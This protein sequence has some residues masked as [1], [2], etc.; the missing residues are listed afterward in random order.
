MCGSNY[1]INQHNKQYTIPNDSFL[2]LIH[3]GTFSHRVNENQSYADDLSVDEYMSI[4][5][6]LASG[7]ARAHGTV[8]VWRSLWRDSAAAARA[9]CERLRLVLEPTGRSRKAGMF[10]QLS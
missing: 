8:P 9:L 3:H 5:Q 2:H 1:K 7:P 6:W 10:L 4:R